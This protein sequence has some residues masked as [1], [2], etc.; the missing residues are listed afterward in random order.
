MLR[1]HDLFDG[2]DGQDTIQGSAGNDALFL[3]DTFSPLPNGTGPRIKNIERFDM[4]A[5][6]DI[7]DLTSSTHSLGDVVLNGDSGNDVLWGSSGNDLLNGGQGNDKLS[8]GLGNDTYQFTRGDNHD[9]IR[10]QDSSANNHDVLSFLHN[11]N[12]DQL[13]FTQ[14]HD[15][16][17][18]NIIGT[19]D[20]VTLA[21][22]YDGATYQVEEIQASD[23]LVLA[24]NQ[25]DQ[26]VQA[27]ASFNPPAVGELSLSDEQQQQLAPVLAASWV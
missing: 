2:G 20:Q 17:R 13:W 5:G 1:S 26:L 15:D 14:D 19:Q 6:D 7:V 22:W 11:I 9:T 8:G 12:H 27:M 18:I 4:G 3:H 16:L 24:N 25:L 21:N 23:G 10:E